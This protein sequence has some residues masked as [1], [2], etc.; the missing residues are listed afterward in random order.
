MADR[1]RFP[2]ILTADKAM[3]VAAALDLIGPVGFILPASDSVPTH[4]SAIDDQG[5]GEMRTVQV[6]TAGAG[7]PFESFVSAVTSRLAEDYFAATSANISSY[8]LGS[9]SPVHYRMKHV[10][11]EFIGRNGDRFFVLAYPNE[12]QLCRSYPY[13]DQRSTSIV[14]LWDVARNGNAVP[15]KGPDGTHILQV[16]RWGSMDRDLTRRTIAQHGYGIEFPESRVSK[17]YY[18]HVD[19]FIKC[20]F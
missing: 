5:G 10:L 7:S 17:R 19:R 6:I 18:G 9:P 11:K 16:A 1:E 3:A 4:L 20:T 8:L 14:R 13:H 15:L 12:R 2:D